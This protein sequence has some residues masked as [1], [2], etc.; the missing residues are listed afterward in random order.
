[1]DTARQILATALDRQPEQISDNSAIGGQE[2]WDSLAHIRLIT[3]I[4]AHLGRE[5]TTDEVI[6]IN[7]LT[8]IAGVIGD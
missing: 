5:M 4:E 2:G 7:S 1:M 6:R 3:A 8:S